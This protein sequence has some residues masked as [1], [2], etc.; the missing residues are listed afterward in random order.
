MEQGTKPPDT[1]VSPCLVRLTGILSGSRH[2]MRGTVLRI[3]RDP[4]NDLVVDGEDASTVSS[5][6]AE[7]RQKEHSYQIYDL[8]STN[9][10]YVDGKRV[11][12]AALQPHSQIALGPN[13][14]QF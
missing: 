8:N 14:P 1:K 3:G 7:I 4:S 13:G 9:G 6:H 5:R 2:M 11:D 10:T 12:Q